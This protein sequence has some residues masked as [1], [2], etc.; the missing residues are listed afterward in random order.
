MHECRLKKLVD[1]DMRLFAKH[2]IIFRK[3]SKTDTLYDKTVFPP[4][5][6]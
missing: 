3:L 6:L 2:H 1:I 4:R 5:R